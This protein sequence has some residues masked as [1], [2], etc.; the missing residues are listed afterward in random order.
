MDE[1]CWEKVIV[2]PLHDFDAQR[3]DS[4]DAEEMGTKP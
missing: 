3:S 2:N 1:S 4:I